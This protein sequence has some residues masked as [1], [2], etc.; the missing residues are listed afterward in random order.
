MCQKECSYFNLIKVKERKDLP[1]PTDQSFPLTH[2]KEKDAND[3]WFYY[4]YAIT[5]NSTKEVFVVEKLGTVDPELIL[6]DYP[7]ICFL[8]IVTKADA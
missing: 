5:K 2:C 1:Q 6:S 7:F 8:F 3:C 4:T